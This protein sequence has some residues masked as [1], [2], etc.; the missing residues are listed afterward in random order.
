MG[1]VMTWESDR[2]VASLAHSS[3]R[4][5]ALDRIVTATWC[6]TRSIGQTSLRSVD[7]RLAIDAWICYSGSGGFLL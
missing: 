5:L 2:S 6:A 3:C 7:L 4:S 1:E